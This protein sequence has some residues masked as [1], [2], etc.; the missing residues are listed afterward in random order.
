MTQDFKKPSD[1][2]SQHAKREVI[3]ADALNWLESYE[4]TL[5]HSFVASMPDISEFPKFSLEQWKSW[6]LETAKL[7][8]SKTSQDGV[9]MFYQS[10]I[11][12]EGEWVDKAYLCQKAAESVGHKLLWHKIVC[13][14][15][16]GTITF[17]R[18]SYTHVLCFSETLILDQGHS[19]AD[20][21][22][23][24]GEKTWERGMG[25]EAAI[26][27]ARFVM[28]DTQTRTLIHP[29]CGEGSML[30]AAEAHGLNT[31]GIERSPKRAE[32]ACLLK[33]DLKNRAFI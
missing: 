4:K 12:H 25:L 31:I 19:T 27:M 5:G 1:P 26:M 7:I 14:Y 28:R 30:A 17:G 29:F 3:C 18:P 10:D 33:L 16:A 20:V 22:D 8:L 21:L 23:T 24:I 6:F 11:K 2:E 13:R 15:P 9:T 32:K